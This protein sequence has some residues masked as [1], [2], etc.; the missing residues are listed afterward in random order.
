M[1]QDITID[2][3]RLHQLASAADR[4]EAAWRHARDKASEAYDQQN[5]LEQALK[6][7]QSE[8]DPRERWMYEEGDPPRTRFDRGELPE[9]P[10]TILDLWEK[11]K[12]A[13]D[14]HQ[15][16]NAEAEELSKTYGRAMQ[17]RSKCARYA[18]SIGQ[19]PAEFQDYAR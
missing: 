1:K 11:I 14:K 18:N 16:L 12:K 13:A 7:M 17:T 9:R 5:S 15:R 10:A 3:D 6:R 8:G 19:L 4:L 2:I